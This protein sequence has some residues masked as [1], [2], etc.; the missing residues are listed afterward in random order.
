MAKPIKSDSIL[1]PELI[2]IIKWFGLVSIALVVFFS[3]FNERRA[4]NTGQDEIFLMSSSARLYFSNVRG[5]NYE[6]EVRRDAGMQI[7]RNKAFSNKDDNSNLALILILNPGKDEAYIYLEPINLDWPITIRLKSMN[8]LESQTFENGNKSDHLRY[9]KILKTAIE[10]SK[11]IELQTDEGWIPIWTSQKD[12]EAIKAVLEDYQ[13][14][15][16]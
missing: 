4:N 3:F 10:G 11:Q 1:T 13:K 16:Q 2:K 6:R 8:G 5:I 14:L 7:F 9:C 15:T 12:K